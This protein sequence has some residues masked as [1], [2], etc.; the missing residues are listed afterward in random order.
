MGK[1][2]RYV[3]GLVATFFAFSAQADWVEQGY[4]HYD[5]LGNEEITLTYTGLGEH[6]Y[7]KLNWDLFLIDTWDGYEEGVL[8][9]SDFWGFTI[10]GNEQSWAFQA[11]RNAYDT[12]PDTT[13]RSYRGEDVSAL[14]VRSYRASPMVMVYENF[15][16]GWVFAHSAETLN[17]TFFATGLQSLTDESWAIGNLFVATGDDPVSLDALGNLQD[18]H[19]PLTPAV[20]A[21]LLLPIG[22]YYRRQKK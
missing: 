8:V 20:L 6:D 17:I 18:V 5:N 1:L 4:S 12:N 14:P 11:S 19:S 7:I 2:Q 9:K 21:G 3:G 16:D 13:G 10:D 15:N 22:V